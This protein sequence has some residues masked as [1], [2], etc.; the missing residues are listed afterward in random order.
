M[1]QQFNQLVK[2]NTSM[3]EN[4][5][6][7]D[8]TDRLISLMESNNELLQK[9]YKSMHKEERRHTIALI[10]HT[11]LTIIAVGT[12]LY[13]TWIL[14]DMVNSNVTALKNFIEKIT[15]DFGSLGSSLKEGWNDLKFW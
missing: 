14:F 5:Q 12:V 6:T 10:Y 2:E 13:I 3:I 11:F 8:K 15:P 7:K 4:G 9:I 1:N